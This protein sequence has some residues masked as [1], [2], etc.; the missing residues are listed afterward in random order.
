MEGLF[1]DAF[2][3][4]QSQMSSQLDEVAQETLK[5]VCDE[6][7]TP[8]YELGTEWFQLKYIKQ[9]FPYVVSNKNLFRISFKTFK[10][11]LTKVY[12]NGVL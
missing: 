8:F 12:F 9:N 1:A 2:E 10:S 4:I 11:Y 3:D 5:R 6:E 7:I